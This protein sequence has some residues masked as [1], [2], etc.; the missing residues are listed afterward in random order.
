M[1]DDTLGIHIYI[2]THMQQA[3]KQARFEIE[4]VDAAMAMEMDRWRDAG[5]MRGI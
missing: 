3:S 5:G 2:H 4:K 1:N